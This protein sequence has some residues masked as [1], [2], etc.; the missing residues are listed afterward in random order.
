MVGDGR[1]R[2]NGDKAAAEQNGD[3]FQGRLRE[4]AEISNA[5]R[6]LIKSECSLDGYPKSPV[7]GFRAGCACNVPSARRLR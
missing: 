2:G 6:R 1:E 3:D 7:I 4:N 5:R